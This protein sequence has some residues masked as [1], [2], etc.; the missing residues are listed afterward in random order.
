VKDNEVDDSCLYTPLD[1][2]SEEDKLAFG[3]TQ[4]SLGKIPINPPP[5]EYCPEL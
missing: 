5:K 2:I 4:F 3:A 1:K